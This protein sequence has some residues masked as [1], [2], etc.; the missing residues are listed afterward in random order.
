M[1]IESHEDGWE[2]DFYP[3]RQ[4]PLRSP[5]WLVIVIIIG[6]IL[7]LTVGGVASGVWLEG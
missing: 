6:I 5:A 2:G 7:A 1:T 3:D 4:K